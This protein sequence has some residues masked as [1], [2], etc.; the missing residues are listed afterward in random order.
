MVRMDAWFLRLTAWVWVNLPV[1]MHGMTSKENRRDQSYVCYDDGSESHSE[2][3]IV[4]VETA[5]Y[6]ARSVTIVHHSRITW[7]LYL[8][9]AGL[10]SG[11]HRKRKALP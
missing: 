9:V 6:I 11:G 4:A 3:G 1:M 5:L 10:P 8:E 7:I 2:S